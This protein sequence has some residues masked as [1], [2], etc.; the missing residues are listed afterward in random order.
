MPWRPFY[1]SSFS[2]LILLCLPALLTAESRVPEELRP[3]LAS[4]KWVRDTDGPVIELGKTGTFDDTHLFAPCVSFEE[5]RYSLWYCGSQNSVKNRVFQM[6][7]ATSGDGIRF[8]KAANNPVFNFGDFQRSILTPTLL[9]SPEG[10][11]LRETG[12]LRMW[13][14]SADFQDSTGLHE[15]Y[16]TASPDGIHWKKPGAAE[17]K[18][19][20][21]PT[22]LK[23]GRTYQMWFTDVSSEPWSFKHASSL[24][25]KRWRVS[26]DPVLEVDQNWESGRLFYPTVL[27]IDDV[28][29]MWYGSYW[30][31]RKNTTAL[32]FAVSIDGLKWY[33][34]PDN[35]VLKP[36]PQRAW[37]SHYVTSQSVMKLPGNHFRIW[38][39]SRKQPPFVNKYF[40]INTAAWNAKPLKKTDQPVPIPEDFAIWKSKTCQ[41]L[42]NQLGIPQNKGALHSEKRG[43][44]ELGNI[45]IEK[46][47]FTSEPGSRIP[48]VIYRPKKINQRAPA[49]V[50]T[51]GHGGSK[52]QWQY[53][54][55]AQAYAKA[56]LI[57][58]AI[59]PIGEEE[60]HIHGKL[61]TR[62]HDPKAIHERAWNAGRPI[63]GKLVFDTMRGIDFLEERDDVD[64]SKIGVAGN[65]LGG[66]VASWMAALEPRLKMA[67]VSGWAY[68]NVTLRSK[69]CTKIPNQMLR[70]SCTWPEFL[71]LAAPNCALLV[72]NG[73]AD[74]II[75]SDDDGTAW[76]GTKSAVQ[77]AS[78]IYQAQ[79]ASGK[80][81]TW[82]EPGGRTP[83]LYYT[84]SRP[85]LDSSAVR[86]PSSDRAGN[87]GSAYHKFRDLGGCQPDSI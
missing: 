10:Q 15:L 68:D 17:L 85:A 43:E 48:A 19:V 77:A 41:K 20:Y 71:S 37:E 60:R 23:T 56:G 38:Y 81:K 34:H 24:D 30:S 57:C 44:F 54:Y 74:W 46:W 40:A 7:L 11:T 6:G 45:V 79:N 59:D 26:P 52:S 9:R 12:Q 5:G 3:W 1:C 28:Y 31:A 58:L 25:G 16:E 66:A 18:H 39:A 4:Q 35:P 42:R 27:K 84:S 86:N 82:F 55:A 49:I 29:L 32:G 21:A 70:E 2:P 75:D 76:R 47:I 13:F 36:D 51:Y 22:I 8:Q 61:G 50:L 64:H 83:A 65:S 87:Q 33:K 62:A 63:M 14:S 72:M 73:D 69:Y 53:N 78:Q 80:V 67:I